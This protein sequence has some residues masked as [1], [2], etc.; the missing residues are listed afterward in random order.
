M[1]SVRIK[2][3]Q[4]YTAA[5]SAYRDAVAG[6]KRLRGPEFERA[7][8]LSELRRASLQRAQHALTLHEREHLCVSQ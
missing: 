2:L 4:Q 7:W 3:R 5:E 8:R 1:C 6:M